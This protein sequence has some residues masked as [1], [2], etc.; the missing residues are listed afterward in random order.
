MIDPETASAEEAEATLSIAEAADLLGADASDETE[1]S[2]AEPDEEELPATEAEPV[3][4]PPFWSA[5]DKA[6][7][8]EQAPEAQAK[9][10]AYEKNRDA[11]TSRALQEAAEARKAAR[12]EAQAL[13]QHRDAIEQL[14][15][16]A[17]AA[18]AENDWD[19]VDWAAWVEE[20]PQA[21]L[22]G[23]LRYDAER[24]QLQ[25]LSAAKQMAE[26]QAFRTYVAEQAQALE[27][28]APEL[29]RD[30][31][32]R[33][34]VGL[35]LVD[36]GYPVDALK[37]VGA[38]DLIVAHK[39]MLWDRANATLKS[40]RRQN[41]ADLRPPARPLRPGAAAHT[42]STRREAEEAKSRFAQSRSRD[43][44]VRLLNLRG[45]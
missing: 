32:R 24:E 9:L 29:A 15:A 2:P 11:A 22:A 37:G 40:P 34:E 33:R 17:A 18:F 12:A 13:A 1:P 26:D 27:A 38:L 25:R 41:D 4:P 28:L 14:A 36:Q 45:R 6:W 3:A 5:E 8:A 43:D 31:G 19:S 23:K 20:D 10:L 30:D 21:A 35:Y 44:A 16:E 42:P 39:A 7:F